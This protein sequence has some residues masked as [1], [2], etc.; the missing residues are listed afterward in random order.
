MM[1]KNNATQTAFDNNKESNESG[2]A[3]QFSKFKVRDY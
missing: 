2:F 1:E 3:E